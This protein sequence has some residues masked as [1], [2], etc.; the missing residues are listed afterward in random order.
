MLQGLSWGNFADDYA[1]VMYDSNGVQKWASR[2]NVPAFSY[3]KAWDLKLD[4]EGNVYVTGQS[5]GSGINYDYCTIKYNNQGGEEWVARYNGPDN[6]DDMATTLAIDPS[7]SV[8]VNGYSYNPPA[9]Y[10]STT[11]MV[12]I[13][14]NS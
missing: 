14:Y 2:Y 9:P 4:G 8:F 12:L 1:T 6:L 10:I 5:G 13:K 3:D 11:D 7:G